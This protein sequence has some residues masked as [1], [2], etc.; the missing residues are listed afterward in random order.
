MT[1]KYGK[2]EMPEKIKLDEASQTAT[3][4]RFIVEPFERGFGHTVGNALRRIMLASMEAPAILSVKIEGV[5]HEYM[6]VEG[7]IEDMTHV[8]LNLKGALLRRHTTVE[9]MHPR[10]V[11]LVTKVLDIT[12]EILEKAGGSYKV[13]VKDLLG[14]S[15]YEVV[16]PEHVIFTVTKPMVKRVDLRI[17]CG[18]GYVPSERHSSFEPLV[19]EIIMDSAFSPVRLVN[20][21]VENTRVGQD[22]D[23]DRLILEVT[24]D[25]RIS[26]VEALTFASQIGIMHLQV[27]DSIKAH[28]VLFDKGEMQTNRDRDEVLG[29]LALK[30]NEIELSVRS[31]N[32]LANANIETIGELVVM[33][34]SDMLRFR[35]FGKKSLTE[36]KQKLDELGLSLGMDLSKYGI[37]R[38]NIKQ[39]IQNYL[40]EKAGAAEV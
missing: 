29:K 13:T 38:D 36:I 21:Y 22:T 12:D 37:N 35:N 33:P 34:E 11:R 4:A 18:R 39:V 16:N 7:I 20:Y 30:I 3:F 40:S 9:D 25:G 2:F 10:D 27:F 32:C 26:P 19:D 1:V 31:T 23:F 24:T 8:I 28:S 17:A 14:E 15:D 6:A 5:P